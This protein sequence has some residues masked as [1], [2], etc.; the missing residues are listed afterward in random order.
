MTRYRIED[1]QIICPILPED[2]GKSLRNVL[3]R[4]RLSQA[5]LHRF[6]TSEAILIDGKPRRANQQV[7][8]GEELR[9]MLDDV[10]SGNVKPEPGNLS[11]IYEDQAILALNKPAGQPC[12]P[13][14]R[15]PAGT[16][17]NFAAAY[18]STSTIQ[19]VNRLDKDTSGIVLLAKNAYYK[20]RLAAEGALTG[21][22]YLAI[23]QG[24]F[25]QPQ[26]LIDLPIARE[27]EGE[28]RRCVR[29]DGQAAQTEVAVIQ[30]GADAALLRLTLITGR[31]HQIRVHLGHLGH[32][33]LGDE[34]YGG[35][36]QII[37]RQ[38]LHAWR[39]TLRHPVSN[40]LHAIEAPI[41]ADIKDALQKCA[42]SLPSLGPINMLDIV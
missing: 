30:Q 9:I 29:M 31:T 20:Q 1:N 41:P 35:N 14:R 16:L 4:L 39:L 25:P 32:P 27:R 3:R 12:H 42:L 8:A 17:A 40:H 21:K 36:C 6:K 10:C 28:I 37:D 2:N 22:T 26:Q 11:I 24:H 15:H 34:L 19:L 5:A 33:L 38:A 23:A 13:S 18:L 7:F